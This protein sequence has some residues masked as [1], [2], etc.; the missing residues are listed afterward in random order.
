MVHHFFFAHVH[1]TIHS[2]ESWS[3]ALIC[4]QPTSNGRL[5][6]YPAVEL[7]SHVR[8]RPSPSECGLDVPLLL[9]AVALNAFGAVRMEQNDSSSCIC[10]SAADR[11]TH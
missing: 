4:V 10:L 5:W 9:S 8:K 11:E 6:R 7:K 1:A 3:I 2:R